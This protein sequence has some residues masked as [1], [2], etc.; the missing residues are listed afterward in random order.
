MAIVLALGLDLVGKWLC[1]HIYITCVVISGRPAVAYMPLEAS[2][3]LPRLWY[4]TL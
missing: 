3:I 4:R 1:T 2:H